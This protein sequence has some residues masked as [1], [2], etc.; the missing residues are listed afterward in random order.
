MYWNVLDIMPTGVPASLL[1]H[2]DMGRLDESDIFFKFL[3][4][5]LNFLLDIRLWEFSTCISESGSYG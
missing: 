3:R 1:L 2:S 5:Y 4:I